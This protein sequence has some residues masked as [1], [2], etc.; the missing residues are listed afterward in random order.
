MACP[1]YSKYSLADLY[2]ALGTVDKDAYS[3]R[4]ELIRKEIEKR[5]V[6]IL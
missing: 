5:E 4:V 1:E 3:D 6:E 2:Q